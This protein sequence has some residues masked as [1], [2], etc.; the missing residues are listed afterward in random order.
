MTTAEMALRIQRPVVAH[1][2]FSEEDANRAYEEW[3][4]NCGPGALAAVMGMT[5]DDVRPHMGDFER[6][7]YT[8]PTLMS[9]A[10]RSIGLPWRKIGARW[11]H[12]GLVRVQWEGPWTEAGV[13]LRVR[14]R[15]THWI[16]AA[17]DRGDIGI[18]DI[19]CMNNGTG[20]C[21]LVDWSDTVVP[22]LVGHYPRAN[23]RWHI[24]HAIEVLVE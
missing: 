22:F 21:S 3:G 9:A 17:I 15:Y 4:A 2:R 16:G 18:F 8:N 23:G 10:L 1:P 11:P 6:K 12:Y 20:W 19:N 14:Y 24:T 7:G 5:L 13:P